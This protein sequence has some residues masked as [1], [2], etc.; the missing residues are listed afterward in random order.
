VRPNAAR[1]VG[2]RGEVRRDPG[3]AIGRRESFRLQP[4][5]DHRHDPEL[6]GGLEDRVAVRVEDVGVAVAADSP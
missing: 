1:T 3:D 5:L 4:R 6:A 2:G